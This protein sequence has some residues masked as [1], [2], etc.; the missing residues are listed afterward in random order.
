[1]EE[2]FSLHYQNY[3]TVGSL[4]D[5]LSGK[6][7]LTYTPEPQGIPEPGISQ[8][9]L[10]KNN[11]LSYAVGIGP[12]VPPE[13]TRLMLVLQADWFSKTKLTVVAEVIPRLLEFYQFE[14]LP[15]LFTQGLAASPSAHLL[16]PVYGAGKLYYQGYLLKAADV[17]D[18]FSWKT[19][20]WPASL[21]ASIL[22][23]PSF[24]VSYLVFTFIQFKKIY[25]YSQNLIPEPDKTLKQDSLFSEQI[26]QLENQLNGVL[27][28]P[29]E[30]SAY[31]Q[32]L[33]YQL[34]KLLAKFS[35]HKAEQLLADTSSKSSDIFQVNNHIHINPDN[36][37]PLI[38]AL[39]LENTFIYEGSRSAVTDYAPD[40][41]NQLVQK[42]YELLKNLEKIMSLLTIVRF[43]RA[44]N[45]TDN[46]DLSDNLAITYRNQVLNVINE[47][48]FAELIHKTISFM[49]ATVSTD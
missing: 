26:A 7:E 14:I 15:Q 33:S 46:P 42:P 21:P 27:R 35:E 28:P 31:L 23:F 45:S 17:H 37:Y 38:K 40:Y 6:I 9:I 47:A 29:Q 2:I 22:Q 10:S 34:G 20:A 8:V 16:L 25:V 5:I 39:V 1:M 43:I 18:I 12:E 4:Q 49:Y 48:V 30:Q 32:D 13:I 11:L 24:G 36:I 44:N 19:P 3:L 41:L